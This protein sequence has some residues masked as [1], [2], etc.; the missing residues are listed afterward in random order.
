MTGHEAHGRELDLIGKGMTTMDLRQPHDLASA[1]LSAFN[2][3]T[4]RSRD[5]PIAALTTISNSL[6][7]P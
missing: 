1:L 7:S 6:S 3:A 2:P 5:A 4:N